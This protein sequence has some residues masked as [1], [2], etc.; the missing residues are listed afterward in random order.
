MADSDMFGEVNMA[1]MEKTIKADI[2]KVAHHGSKR[3]CLEMFLDAVKPQAAVITCGRKNRFG[4]PSEDALS[5][6]RSANISIYRT[7]LQGEIII[8]KKSGDIMIKSFR[9]RAEKNPIRLRNILL[10][11]AVDR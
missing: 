1:H 10:G 6:L 7:D 2:L 3:S 9:N 11:G 5:R 4:L 8:S